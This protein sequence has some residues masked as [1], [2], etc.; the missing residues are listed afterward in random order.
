MA[1]GWI[2]CYLVN[3]VPGSVLSTAPEFSGR[4]VVTRIADCGAPCPASDSLRQGGADSQMTSMLRFWTKLGKAPSTLSLH[5]SPP[6]FCYCPHVTSQTQPSA[7]AT[8]WRGKLPF[9]AAK[10]KQAYQVLIQVFLT[11]E[12]SLNKNSLF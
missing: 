11:L 10:K 5:L 1:A 6:R 12:F 8:Q 7:G 9:K 2:I 4:C 3:C